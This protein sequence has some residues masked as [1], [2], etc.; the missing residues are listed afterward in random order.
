MR[1]LESKVESKKF[2]KHG[3]NKKSKNVS[4]IKSNEFNWF[5]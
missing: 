3:G 4:I 1:N 5:L 2:R